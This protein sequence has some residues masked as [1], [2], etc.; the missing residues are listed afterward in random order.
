MKAS[1]GFR[2]GPGNNVGRIRLGT[3]L[4]IRNT[5]TLSGVILLCLPCTCPTSRSST[6]RALRLTFMDRPSRLTFTFVAHFQIKQLLQFMAHSSNTG[7]VAC[8][9]S[10]GP[11]KL[12]TLS[13]GRPS[14]FVLPSNSSKLLSAT[15][16]EC[17]CSPPDSA[18]SWCVALAR[19][20]PCYG[21]PSEH[22]FSQRR[23]PACLATAS[24]E[25]VP[26]WLQLI[27]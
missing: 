6:G 13:S 9:G 15:S 26:T 3:M 4:S 24:K 20:G 22:P 16:S 10:R 7:G 25:S 11:W 27:A 12:S 8:T 2:S 19:R 1:S 23:A 18:Y 5:S 17:P 21:K 14:I